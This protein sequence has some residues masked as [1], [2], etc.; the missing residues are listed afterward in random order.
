MAMALICSSAALPAQP[1]V[2]GT[3]QM[4][5]RGWQWVYMAKVAGRGRSSKGKRSQQLELSQQCQRQLM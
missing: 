1:S 3:E 2:L 5:Q 4:L